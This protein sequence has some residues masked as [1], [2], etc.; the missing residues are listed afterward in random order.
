MRCTE[1]AHRAGAGCSCGKVPVG[2]IPV[3]EV[4][5]GG[6]ASGEELDAK[7]PF[8]SPAESEADAVQGVLDSIRRGR[9]SS[10]LLREL[11]PSARLLL[12]AWEA[13]VLA[14][15]VDRPDGNGRF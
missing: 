11:P 13:R 9:H 14:H 1:R 12:T 10:K 6:P 2:D 7:V 3:G 15:G 8:G 4:P 5:V